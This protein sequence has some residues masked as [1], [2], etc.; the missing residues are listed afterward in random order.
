VIRKTAANDTAPPLARLSLDEQG[1]SRL[2]G[3]CPTRTGDH[4]ADLEAAKRL[5][6]DPSLYAHIIHAEPTSVATAIP[7]PHP[8]ELSAQ[9]SRPT[10]P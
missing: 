10:T 3:T 8:A 4:V 5:L 9:S 6:A 1:W 2:R 7:Q